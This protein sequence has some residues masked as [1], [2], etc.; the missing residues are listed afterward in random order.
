M[1]HRGLLNSRLPAFGLASQPKVCG[2]GGHSAIGDQST[3][4]TWQIMFIEVIGTLVG[5]LYPNSA[6]DSD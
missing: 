2:D 4:E 1:F 5:F 3:L 6:L